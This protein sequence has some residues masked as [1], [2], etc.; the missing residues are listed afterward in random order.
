MRRK[1]RPK[2]L[3]LWMAA[4]AENRVAILDYGA[5]VAVLEENTDVRAIEFFFHHNGK[6]EKV[7]HL[8]G[9]EDLVG[10]WRVWSQPGEMGRVWKLEIHQGF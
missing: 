9:R 4:S 1:P 3:K 10:P 8:A 7:I 5:V 2:R 6:T